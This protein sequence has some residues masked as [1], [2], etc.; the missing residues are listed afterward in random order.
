MNSR[1]HRDFIFWF[2]LALFLA[3]IFLLGR[4]L[5]P[6]IS[7]IVIAAVVTGLFSP[8]YQFLQ[9][10]LN[11]SI[12]SALTCILI[13]LTLFIPIV[14]FVGILAQQAY[15][16]YLM[17]RSAV[18][19]EQVKNLLENSHIV[20]R[21][22]QF[23]GHFN[24]TLSGDE[25]QKSLSE[26]GKVVGLFLF[27]Q[28]RSIAQNTLS[29]LANFFLM[30]LVIYFL[31]IDG[32][33]AITF[34]VDL[35]PLP[36]DQDEKLIQKF[37]DMS[38]AILIGNGL[39]GLI[40]GTCGGVLFALFGIKSPFL[41]GVIMGILAFLPIIGIG[42]V[43]IP[44]SIYLFLTGRI[45]AG[46]FFIIFYIILSGSVEYLWKPKIV[47]GKVQ[48][49]T[50]LVFLSIIGGLKLFGILGIIYGP[51]IITAFLTLTDIYYGSY[52]QMIAPSD[53]D[54]K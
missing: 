7:I 49:H 52:H 11:P 3:S 16:L 31:L 34:I 14:F 41:W 28:S 29:F 1:D 5:W 54:S 43:L 20:E 39:G 18:I 33:R 46:I 10:K 42:A 4:L 36:Q 22:N 21:I 13:F 8:V 38:G 53:G 37:K 6:F 35:S 25:F 40:Q 24:I 17:G 47:G 12:S 19:S 2:F 15:D 48:M 45:A 26:L 44:A 9:Q 51:L 27:E 30:L 50:L 23:L 32:R